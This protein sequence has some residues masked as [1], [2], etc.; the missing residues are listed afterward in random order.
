MT[1]GL[2]SAGDAE[3][4]TAARLYDEP[5]LSGPI[6]DIPRP[7]PDGR[8]VAC[9]KHAPGGGGGRRVTQGEWRISPYGPTSGAF[10]HSIVAVDEDAGVVY[11]TASIDTPLERHLYS[12]SYRTPGEPVRLTKAP[13]WWLVAMAPSAPRSFVGTHSDPRTPPNVGLYGLDGARIAW[14]TENRLA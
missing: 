7:S 6:S 9:S 10:G 4:L 12:Q 13:G 14:V 2:R 5:F 8:L 1:D 3:K 11:F